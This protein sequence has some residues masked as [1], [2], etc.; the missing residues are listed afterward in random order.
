MKPEA[1]GLRNSLNKS[2][3]SQTLVKSNLYRCKHTRERS[4]KTL[5]TYFQ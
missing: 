2:E 1:K 5:E 4:Q 3:T